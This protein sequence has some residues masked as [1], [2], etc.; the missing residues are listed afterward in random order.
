MS[1]APLHKLFSRTDTL[2]P[3]YPLS[4]C[5]G[6]WV[7]VS[8]VCVSLEH[9]R[10]WQVPVPTLKIP[11]LCRYNSHPV[12]WKHTSSRVAGEIQKPGAKDWRLTRVGR[13]AFYF[14]ILSLGRR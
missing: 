4:G 8:R 5:M 6:R 7:G 10:Q 9:T 12:N 14:P 1:G 2:G 11:F 13:G 3:R